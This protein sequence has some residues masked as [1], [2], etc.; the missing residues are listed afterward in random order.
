MKINGIRGMWAILACMLLLTFCSCARQ[1]GTTLT[2]PEYPEMKIGF[3]TQNFMQSMPFTVESLEELI[4]YAAKKGYGFIQLRD[5]RAELSKEDCERLTAYADSLGIRVIYEIHVNLLHPDFTEVFARGTENAKLFGQ[6]AILRA[7]LTGSEFEGKD[8]KTGW[9]LEEL[10]A[11]ALLAEECAA[12]ADSQGV[13]FVV[14]N[15][16]EPFFGK[17]PAYF[18]LADLFKHTGKVG[19]QFDLC[20]AFVNNSRMKADPDQVAAFLE[21]LGE[22]WVTTHVKTAVDGVPQPVVG[23]N[24]ISVREIARMMGEGGVQYFAL[25]LVAVEDKEACFANHEASIKA[26]TEMGLLGKK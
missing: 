5:S 8:T 21:Q 16:M 10:T 3:S 13:R 12:R 18:G 14:E 7:P 2:F 9:T 25:E 15:V 19:L 6:P 17:S 4:S 20:N 22:R 1:N 24:P 11:A 26:L 23:D